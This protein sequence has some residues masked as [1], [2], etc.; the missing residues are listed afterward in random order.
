MW[1]TLSRYLIA[2]LVK[3]PV[4]PLETHLSVP[5]DG[6]SVSSWFWPGVYYSRKWLYWGLQ[7]HH[8]WCRKYLNCTTGLS[9]AGVVEAFSHHFEVFFLVNFAGWSGSHLRTDL[10]NEYIL[11]LAVLCWSV[12]LSWGMAVFCQCIRA[13]AI[14]LYLF[15]G[16]KMCC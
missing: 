2:T 7:N 1:E 5:R 11:H 4:G 9:S 3:K 14:E 13:W 10:S 6:C 8:F 16:H 12:G 15:S